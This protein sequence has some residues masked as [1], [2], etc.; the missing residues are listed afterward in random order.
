MTDELRDEDFAYSFTVTTTG[1]VQSAHDAPVAPVER[2]R[3]QREIDI[4]ES[5]ERVK[6]QQK[7]VQEAARDLTDKGL[8]LQKEMQ[9]L[10][11]MAD[12]IDPDWEKD[13]FYEFLFS[14]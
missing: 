3:S 14:D 2:V 13:P 9:D 12:Q 10:F 5:M 4:K 1:M 11:A 7:S 6:R 8:S